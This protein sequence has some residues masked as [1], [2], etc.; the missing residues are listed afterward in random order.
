[1][2]FEGIGR[3]EL[4]V[5]IPCLN[6]EKS[7]RAT[8]EEIFATVPNSTVIV[9]D[10]NSRDLTA[11]VAQSAGAFVVFQ[12]SPGKGRAFRSALKFLPREFDALFMVDGDGTYEIAPIRE[13]LKMIKDGGIDLVVGKRVSRA[14]ASNTYRRGHR[15]GNKVFTVLNRFFHAS[16]IEDSLS[17]WRLMSHSFARTFPANSKGFEIE[18]ELNAHVRN[19]DMNVANIDVIY[20]ERGAE[21][22]SKLRTYKDG[23]RI[24]FSNFRIAL[25]NRPLIFLGTPSLFSMVVSIP[26]VVRALKGYLDTGLVPQLPSLIVGISLF[27]GGSTVLVIGYLL[28]QM[29]LTYISNTRQNYLLSLKSPTDFEDK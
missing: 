28:E 7:I 11:K 9:V 16:S 24:L 10:N 6:E 1:M 23:F 2:T 4:V 18:T 14:D 13:A 22:I 3:C 26:L 8:V 17:G 29:R 21:S 19:F 20:R 25:Q 27:M 12:P 15:F 5:V